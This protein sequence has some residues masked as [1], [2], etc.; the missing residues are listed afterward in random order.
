MNIEALN[1]D[2]IAVLQKHGVADARL[3]AA[4][5][6]LISIISAPGGQFVIDRAIRGATL[7]AVDD[8]GSCAFHLAG[9]AR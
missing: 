1:S 5:S 6:G 9:G 7:I 8:S 4:L 2:V 3:V